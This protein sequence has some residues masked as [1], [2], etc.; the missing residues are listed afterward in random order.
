M[1]LWSTVALGLR[2]VEALEISRFL[3]LPSYSSEYEVI[4]NSEKDDRNQ[5]HDQEVAKLKMTTETTFNKSCQSE[6]RIRLVI[7][8]KLTA[9]KIAQLNQLFPHI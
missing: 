7:V 6:Q 5:A 4:K 9:G 1:A 8:H 2:Q 3:L